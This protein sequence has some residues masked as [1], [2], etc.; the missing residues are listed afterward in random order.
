MGEYKTYVI[1]ADVKSSFASLINLLDKN[2]VQYSSGSRTNANGY[3]NFT[4]K[5]ESF[6][7][8]ENDIII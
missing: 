2:A 7:V 8:N 5:E 6:S 3:N 1:K 4:G